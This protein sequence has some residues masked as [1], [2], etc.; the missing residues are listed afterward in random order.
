MLSL[1][2]GHSVK[3]VHVCLQK[4]SQSPGLSTAATETH[5]A[6]SVL[7]RHTHRS[8]QLFLQGHR[9]DIHLFLQTLVLTSA[10]YE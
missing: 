3:C 1:V 10:I 8:A 6:G 5:A 2:Y 9:V 4:F 7:C